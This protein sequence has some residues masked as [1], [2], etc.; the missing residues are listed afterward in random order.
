MYKENDKE[1][2]I[3]KNT[4]NI[5]NYLNIKDIWIDI[6]TNKKEFKEEL[7]EIKKLKIQINQILYIYELLTDDKTKEEDNKYYDEV[8]KEIERRIEKSETEGKE[9]DKEESAK[10]EK[11]ED[12]KSDI[13]TRRN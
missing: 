11:S 3:L 4:N 13:R 6:S 8:I 9:S 12:E 7:K 1:E 10:S 5:V 2:K